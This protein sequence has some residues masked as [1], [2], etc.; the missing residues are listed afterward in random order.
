MD[1]S[2]DTLANA[3]QKVGIS[4]HHTDL[5]WNELAKDKSP[6]N[7]SE[8]KSESKFDLANVTY[9]IGALIVISAMTWFL[10]IGWEVFGG[11]GIFAIALCYI[12]IFFFMGNRLWHKNDLKVPGGLLITIAVCLI[13]LAIYGFQLW[14]GLWVVDSPGKYA[15]FY[16]WIKGGWFLMEIGTILGASLALYFYSFPFLTAPLFFS[17]WFMSMDVTPLLFGEGSHW[18]KSLWV[19]LWVGLITLVVAYCIDRRAKK[20]FAFWGYLFGMLAFWSGLTLLD[21]P[22]E[23]QRGIYCLINVLLILVSVLLQR[24]VFLI[25]G[26]LGVFGYIGSLFFRYFYESTFFPFILSGIGVLIIFLG[27]VYSKHHRKFEQ[28]LLDWV[29]KGFKDYLPPYGK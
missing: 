13:P 19:S 1:I 29:P 11:G 9:Y 12:A 4:V 25:F 8:S 24:K 18:E 16:N 28:K 7:S 22:S 17:V 27:T 3:A 21:T 2:K 26:V 6:E 14:T 23:F 5:L 15:D 10:G 20:D